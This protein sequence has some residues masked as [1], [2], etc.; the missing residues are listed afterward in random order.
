MPKS[1]VG[2]G[3]RDRI[4][5]RWRVRVCSTDGF[6]PMGMKRVI[7]DTAVL[8][9]G[10]AA[11]QLIALAFYPWL[12]RI[13]GPEAFGV[14]G[15]FTALLAVLLPIVT[16]SIPLAIVLPRSSDEAVVLLRTCVLLPIPL[17]LAVWFVGHL[18]GAPL[19]ASIPTD[20]QCC[21]LP[22]LTMAALVNGWTQAASQWL[23][24]VHAF[25]DLAIINVI[26]ALIGGVIKVAAGVVSPAAVSLLAANT[27]GY[28][29]WLTLAWSRV[30]GLVPSK[31]RESQPLDCREVASKYWDFPAYRMPQAAVSALSHGLPTLI[32]A[33]LFG[34]ASAGFY[35][36]A[37][38]VVVTPS[39]LIAK[40]SMTV[41]TPRLAEASNAGESIV[42]PVVKSTV[43]LFA[44]GAVPFLGLA[45]F[46][47]AIFAIMFGEEWANSGT[48]A[49]WLSV[50]Y[51]VGFANGPAVAA[52]PVLRRQRFLLIWELVTTG[53][54][55]MALVLAFV[56]VEDDIL[57]V[58][59]YS[60]IGA[61]CYLFLI[62][63]AIRASI[64][65]NSVKCL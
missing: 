24:R 32:L 63:F 1:S 47:P 9:A 55:A 44:L 12:T 26:Q 33:G 51:W 62:G 49:S 10:T 31:S 28:I 36:L 21:F 3:V 17:S 6:L 4:T 64:A 5:F 29:V 57:A 19:L 58:S 35:A 34:P 65:V 61:G 14:F 11:G 53:L 59:A 13:Y 22:L 60:V 41:L 30:R 46:G 45:L 23:A 18:G 56:V 8:S 15:I 38:L 25:R 39:A 2:A 52:I 43:I 37:R 48:Y 7:R 16:L 54:K 40:A 50:M 27:L 42:G 20:V